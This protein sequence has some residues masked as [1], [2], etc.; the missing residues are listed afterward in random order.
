MT[1]KIV[2]LGISAII[3]IVI[4]SIIIYR[5]L[6]NRHNPILLEKTM[7]ATKKHFFNRNLLP[8]SSINGGLEY[9][10]SFWI[11]ISNWSYKYGLEK[12]ILF[13]K[14]EP[15]TESKKS[16]ERK[17]RELENDLDYLSDK[18]STKPTKSSKKKE[19]CINCN[20]DLL[21]TFDNKGSDKNPLSGLIVSLAKK[22]NTLIIR[23]TLIDESISVLKIPDLPIQK[24]LNISISLQLRTVDVF[25]NGEL[26]ASKYLHT[27]PTYYNGNLLVN[28]NG[29]F[30]GYISNVKYYNKARNIKE[31]KKEFIKGPHNTDI[32]NKGEQDIIN[33][34]NLTNLTGNGNGN[35]N[36]NDNNNDNNNKQ[37]PTSKN[38]D[39]NKVTNPPFSLGQ[40]CH[41]NSDCKLDLNCVQ[42]KCIFKNQSRDLGET[43]W[44]NSNCKIGLNC[45][46]YGPDTLNSTQVKD[47]K[48]LGIPV[49][50]NNSFNAKF[51]NKPFTCIAL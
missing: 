4:L 21:E 23:T 46:N 9:T 29:G 20:T 22:L 51:K 26:T 11:Y 30:E 41:N 15:T 47:L 38:T 24:W 50:E 19:E 27:L 2:G 14:G 7:I 43:C 25:I 5:Y 13:W 16:L 36:G 17:C 37:V 31:I 49:K 18:K 1:L 6:K 42:G 45:N 44:G 35:G 40:L 12:Y 39:E 3:L 28:P 34:T 48:R 33:L 32:I 10:L 8:L